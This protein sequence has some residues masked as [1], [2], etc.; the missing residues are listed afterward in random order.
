M[1]AVPGFFDTSVL[2]LHE[3][4]APSG[5][6]AP[7]A[8]VRGRHTYRLHPMLAASWGL[9]LG[10]AWAFDGYAN[11]IAAKGR[12]EVGAATGAETN[13]DMQLMFDASAAMGHKK[14]MF[15]IGVEYQ[16][17]NNKFGNTASLTGGNGYRAKTPM[18]RAEY[19][20]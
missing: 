4:N 19:H 9:P 16:Y 1:W 7:I 15:R 18:I 11:W 12:S 6:F 10:N 14:G 8:D 2:L 5:A 20:F 3:S 17:W 13:V